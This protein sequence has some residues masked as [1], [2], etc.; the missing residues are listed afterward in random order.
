MQDYAE[1]LVRTGRHR[2]FQRRVDNFN[3]CG[4]ELPAP[5]ARL[6]TRTAHAYA[7]V[8]GHINIKYQLTLHGLE[9]T[10]GGVLGGLHDETHIKQVPELYTALSRI[11]PLCLALYHSALSRAICDTTHRR[12]VDGTNVDLD[13]SVGH[14]R[15]PHLVLGIEALIPDVNIA[16]LCEGELSSLEIV[17]LDAGA[18]RGS[19]VPVR[20]PTIHRARGKDFLCNER[21]G[22]YGGQPPSRAPSYLPYKAQSTI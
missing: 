12:V 13:R 15:R 4:H 17:S 18:G 5:V 22:Q 14:Q 1:H 10:N 8:V 16:G 21:Q 2:T 19:V 3:G 20:Q 7:V 9:V 11:H 6:R